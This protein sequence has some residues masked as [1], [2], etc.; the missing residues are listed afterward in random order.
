MSFEKLSQSLCNLVDSYKLLSK[1]EESEIAKKAIAGDKNAKEILIYSNIKFI[2][3]IAKNYKSK[4][5]VALEDLIQTGLLGMTKALR[6]F[7]PEK[8]IKFITFAS[9]YIKDEILKEC[10][11]MGRDIK[12][13]DIGIASFRKLKEISK[14]Y[15][16][17]IDS[18]SG[19]K[20]LAEKTG[21]PTWQIKNILQ[22]NVQSASLD[23]NIENDEKFSLKNKLCVE[24]NAEDFIF[25]TDL[26]NGIEKTI[27]D[28]ND[29][30]IVEMKLGLN[31]KK[32]SEREI[33]KYL[34]KINNKKISHTTIN[35]RYNRCIE[36]LKRSRF[37]QGYE[38]F[39]N[40]A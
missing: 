2:I 32:I 36:L 10:N 34:T 35:N 38:D 17:D 24:S 5:N 12:L 19:Q 39:F 40:V 7:N 1:E 9:F 23:S 16:I 22:A 25:M 29:R 33:A 21:I 31:C 28:K 6:N 15:N 11:C 37:M 27:K 26:K 3:K 18:S 20:E 4:Y 8:N 13:S 14:S 30:L